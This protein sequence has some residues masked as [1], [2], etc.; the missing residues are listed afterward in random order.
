MKSGSNRDLVGISSHGK[1]PAVQS[2][3]PAVQTTG[4][5]PRISYNRLHHAMT[6][7]AESVKHDADQ[8][9]RQSSCP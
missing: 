7:P 4:I 3:H 9:A 6:M 8:G 2:R 5:S 1:H